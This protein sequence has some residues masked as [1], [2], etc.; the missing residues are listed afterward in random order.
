MK[1]GVVDVET[2]K[3][4]NKQ[5]RAIISDMLPGVM[6]DVALILARLKRI[7]EALELK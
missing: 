1:I 7:Y 5:H 4:V 6:V 3:E 2:L